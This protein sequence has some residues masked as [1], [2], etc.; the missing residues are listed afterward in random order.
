ML[1]RKRSVFAATDGVLAVMRETDARSARGVDFS[2]TDGLTEVVRLDFRNSRLRTEDYEQTDVDGLR[3]TRKVICRRLDGVDP[4]ATVTIGGQVFDVTRVDTAA[5]TMT[6]H[7]SQLVTDGTAMLVRTVVARDTRGESR[8]SDV[9]QPVYVLN[10]RAGVH[11]TQSAGLDGA[12]PT[13]TITIRACDYAGETSLIRNGR[14][15]K[16]TRATGTG[17]W[18]TLECEG[19]AVHHG[20]R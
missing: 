12:W 14:D 18:L 4:G 20:E 11:A 3:V 10:G 17:E 9:E 19:G 15:Y 7:L 1:R 16:V 5:K 6:L 13:A 8:R 2:S